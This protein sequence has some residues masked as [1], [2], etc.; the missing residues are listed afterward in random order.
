MDGCRLSLMITSLSHGNIITSDAA[1][2]SRSCIKGTERNMRNRGVRR[3]CNSCALR[4]AGGQELK[5]H[6]QQII[7]LVKL[8]LL[9][10]ASL[11]LPRLLAS[12]LLLLPM[13]L[14]AFT[15]TMLQDFLILVRES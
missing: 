1:R 15:L 2:L 12:P 7:L 3:R 14:S 11:L 13:F 4:E 9:P 5:G 8:F 6:G 10:R